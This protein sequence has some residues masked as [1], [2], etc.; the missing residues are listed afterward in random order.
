M[1]RMQLPQGY[2]PADT[3][4]LQENKK[5]GDCGECGGVVLFCLPDLIGVCLLPLRVSPTGLGN[6]QNEEK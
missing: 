3:T 5:A 4:D 6:R 2:R 1:N